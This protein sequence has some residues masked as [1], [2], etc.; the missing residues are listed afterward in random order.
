M[1]RFLEDELLEVSLSISECRQNIQC[2]PATQ[3]MAGTIRLIVTSIRNKLVSKFHRLPSSSAADAPI[4]SQEPV[5]IDAL[6]EREG[7]EPPRPFDFT[8]VHRGISP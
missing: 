6:L 5:R 8:L 4:S 1:P 2:N 3:V 7:F